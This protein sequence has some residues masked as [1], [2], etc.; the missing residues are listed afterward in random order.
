MF[1]V[2]NMTGRVAEFHQDHM[3]RWVSQKGFSGKQ[4]TII[5]AY[6]AVTDRHYMGF[7][8]VTTQQRNILTQLE[9]PVSEPRKA[10]YETFANCYKH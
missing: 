9:D 6:Q 10:F 7:L 1:S 5:S 8:T 2:G 4:V 3:G